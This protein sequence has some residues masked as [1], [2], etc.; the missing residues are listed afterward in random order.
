M[1]T[2][3]IKNEAEVKAELLKSYEEIRGQVLIRKV[4][5]NLATWVV[6]DFES[7][8]NNALVHISGK[9]TCILNISTK[10]CVWIFAHPAKPIKQ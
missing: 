7:L 10:F 8:V 4:E 6:R 3:S 1:A 9:Y 5:T 2:R